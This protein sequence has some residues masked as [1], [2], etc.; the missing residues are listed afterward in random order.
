MDLD[1]AR[2]IAIVGDVDSCKTSV[3][4]NLLNNYKGKRDKALYC[5]P[6][7][8]LPYRYID[9]LNVLAQLE[10]TIIVID[11]FQLHFPIYSNRMASAKLFDLI[12]LSRHKNV[13]LILT[14]QN[15]QNLPRQ[16][17]NFFDGYILTHIA[18]LKLIKHAGLIK[19]I[20]NDIYTSPFVNRIS[21]TLDLKKGE[22]YQMLKDQDDNGFKTFIN[23]NIKKD[24]CG[25]TR[26]NSLDEYKEIKIK[27][28][29]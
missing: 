16:L 24:W 19:E 12:S 7:R 9:S 4:F 6:N 25:I 14:T 18:H 17:E 29:N 11:E 3:A 1:K 15:S 13:T 28:N 5:Y 20:V 2:V 23:P 26:T 21:E 8:T 22:Y 27:V 10:N